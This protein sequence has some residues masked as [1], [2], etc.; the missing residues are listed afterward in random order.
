MRRAGRT[1]ANQQEIVSALRWAGAVVEVHS[2]YPVG[3]DVLVH[4][5]GAT[6]RVEIKDGTRKPSERQLTAAE[7][8][9]QA[10]NPATYAV[11]ESVE[12]ALG[13]INSIE[14]RY[15]LLQRCGVTA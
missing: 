8:A 10:A 4:H 13:L 2:S 11:V 6:V 9:A 12:Q 3:Y 7:Q 1:D 15:E 5:C 14:K